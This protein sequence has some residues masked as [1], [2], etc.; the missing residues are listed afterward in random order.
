MLVVLPPVLLGMMEWAR[1]METT[2]VSPSLRDPP[3]YLLLTAR[4]SGVH[5]QNEQR[6][7]G[8]VLS[9]VMWMISLNG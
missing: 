7:P 9:K 4:K 3:L 1:K 5:G 6:F 8:K 2:F